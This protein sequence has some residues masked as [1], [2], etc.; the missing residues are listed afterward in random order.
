MS[1]Q[2][3]VV[4]AFLLTLSI[5]AGGCDGKSSTPA[6][7]TKLTPPA[8]AAKKFEFFDGEKFLL[9]LQWAQPAEPKHADGASAIA[10]LSIDKVGKKHVESEYFRGGFD[11]RSKWS[12]LEEFG[13]DLEAIKQIGHSTSLAIVWGEGDSQS[14]RT[15]DIILPDRSIVDAMDISGYFLA[16][17]AVAKYGE[18]Q[19]AERASDLSADLLRA[20]F[21]IYKSDSDWRTAKPRV[22]ILLGSWRAAFELRKQRAKVSENADEESRWSKRLEELEVA[23]R[24]AMSA[25]L[26]E[27][28]RS[29]GGNR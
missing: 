6:N 8:A 14:R 1:H 29:E 20:G 4:F 15:N 2:L 26:V 19:E 17:A 12:P 10:R 9:P 23:A 11:P 21:A 16:L 7:R 22:L 27:Q 24:S 13:N 5:A 18:L 25:A 28:E 3:V